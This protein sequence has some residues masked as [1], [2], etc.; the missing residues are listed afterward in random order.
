MRALAAVAL[1]LMAG[2]ALAQT[3][4]VPWDGYWRAPAATCAQATRHTGPDT[5]DETV[6]HGISAL[7]LAVPATWQVVMRCDD[8]GRVWTAPR[9]VMLGTGRM[10]IWFGPGGSAP[11]EFLRCE[12]GGEY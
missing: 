10:W 1:I 7:A 2:P 4:P 11:M 3:W 6:C 5:V 12:S 9:I 8:G